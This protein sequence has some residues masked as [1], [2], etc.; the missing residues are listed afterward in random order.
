MNDQRAY[1]DETAHRYPTPVDLPLAQR[2]ELEHLERA[3]GSIPGKTIVDFGAGSGRVTF[4]FLKKGYNVTAVDISPKS[5][6]DLVRHYTQQKQPSWGILLTSSRLPNT[7]FDAIVGADILHHVDMQVHLPNLYQI[8]KPGGRIAFSEPNAWFF[9][10]YVYIFLRSLP[11]AIER[12]ILHM[13]VSKITSELHLAGFSHIH[14]AG[15]PFFRRIAFRFIV[16]AT[17]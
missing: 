14:I 11:W 13:T 6:S 2:L 17:K 1:F 10:W 9:L 15:F 8:L 5:L 4:W 12:G 16:T 3:L 7:R